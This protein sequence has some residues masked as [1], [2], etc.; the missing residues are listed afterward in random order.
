MPVR[1][2]MAWK[3]AIGN[4]NL[5]SENDFFFPPKMLCTYVQTL[6]RPVERV[7]NEGVGLF[8]YTA[9]FERLLVLPF[10][11]WSIVTMFWLNWPAH[12]T[13]CKPHSI[14][15]RQGHVTLHPGGGRSIMLLWPYL[16]HLLSTKEK[17]CGLLQEKKNTEASNFTN[18]YQKF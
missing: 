11:F 2:M 14:F 18:P 7:Q 5:G 16:E 12:F 10:A 1:S 15:Q 13:N 8:K 17:L 9:L 6:S 3:W 4:G